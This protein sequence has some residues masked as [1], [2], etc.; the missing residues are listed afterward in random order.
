M[1]NQQQKQQL[2]LPHQPW[3]STLE[4]WIKRCL[5]Q[6]KQPTTIEI[7]TFLKRII[8]IYGMQG[9]WEIDWNT[10]PVIDLVESNDISTSKFW[11]SGT[12]PVRH[13][14]LNVERL[15]PCIPSWLLEA[16][17]E[18]VASSSSLQISPLPTP[19][20]SPPLPAQQQPPQTSSS[21][22]FPPKRQHSPQANPTITMTIRP[23]ALNK[24]KWCGPLPISEIE[25]PDTMYA[26]P[27]GE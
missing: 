6:N 15:A 8:E 20:P 22:S 3:P 17:L 13:V 9:I 1:S 18:P 16:D 26:I 12:Q 21:S 2:Q 14:D 25:V 7:S 19:S 23:W 11:W 5:L 10:F 4:P 24:S 27:P